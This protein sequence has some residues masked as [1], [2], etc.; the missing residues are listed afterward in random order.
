VIFKVWVY[1]KGVYLEEPVFRNI[2]STQSEFWVSYPIASVCELFTLWTRSSPYAYN[3]VCTRSDINLLNKG[4]SF[5]CMI[6]LCPGLLVAPLSGGIV[7][8]C[9]FKVFATV[10]A[11]AV[12]SGM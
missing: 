7:S 6:F 4:S 10:I 3:F 11:C 1:L 2:Y 8:I 9:L 5:S 12:F